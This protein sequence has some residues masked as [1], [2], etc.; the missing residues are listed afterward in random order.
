MSSY[1]DYD[2]EGSAMCEEHI[3]PTTKIDKPTIITDGYRQP[4]ADLGNLIDSVEFDAQEYKIEYLIDNIFVNK[5]S[6][7]VAGRSKTL[8]TTVGVV[9]LFYSL[10]TKSDFL[11][12]FPVNRKVR[13]G[14]LSCESG[15]DVL[16]ETGRRI[17]ASRGRTLNDAKELF[18]GEKLPRLGTTPG[19]NALYN[20]IKRNGLEYIAIDPA[21]VAM[22]R[23][24]TASMQFIGGALNDAVQVCKEADCGFVLCH[25]TKEQKSFAIPTMD[26]ITGAGYEESMRQ[27]MLLGR[28]K[29][30]N[31]DGRHELWLA[32]GGSV[33]H[34]GIWYVDVNEGLDVRNRIYDVQVMNYASGKQQTKDEEQLIKE[35]NRIS[36]L[37]HDAELILK[38]LTESGTVETKTGIQGLTG[39]SPR[40]I[41][42]TLE[43]LLENKWLKPGKTKAKDNQQ[44]YPGW[45]VA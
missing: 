10:A 3:T 45:G 43:Y 8:K 4:A 24:N 37:E 23:E 26:D 32:V 31:F 2:F 38:A 30:F 22:P 14:I 7:I 6:C 41:S 5:Q 33:G 20:I 28:R 21:Y 11:N 13:C 42:T 9:D 15:F 17:A 36:I 35:N 39:L 16:Q 40:R 19:L 27:W 25:H 34:S 44:S 29:E 18:W 12:T 1:D